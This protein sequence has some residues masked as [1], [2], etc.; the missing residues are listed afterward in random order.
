MPYQAPHNSSFDA[1]GS[2]SRMMDIHSQPSY[3]PQYSTDGSDQ[4]VNNF[5]FF[6]A[7]PPAAMMNVVGGGYAAMSVAAFVPGPAI[8]ES[9]LR[10]ASLS[11]ASTAKFNDELAAL[12]RLTSEVCPLLLTTSPRSH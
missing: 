8:F 7:L 6:S 10:D 9:L 1:P 4:G 2:P 5:Q 11:G 3:Q 12:N